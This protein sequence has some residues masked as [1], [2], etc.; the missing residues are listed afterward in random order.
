MNAVF[1]NLIL[2][3]PPGAGKGTQAKMMVEE[4]AIP[5]IS[6]GDILR[7]EVA[8]G[9]EL[10]KK[11]KSYMDAG[12]LVPDDLILK[13]V[14]GRLGQKDCA[15]GFILDG[16][17]RTIPQ[18]EGL[19]T[20]L[21]ELNKKLDGV[22]SIE[23]DDEEL[24]KRLT[25]RWISHSTG[26]IYNMLFDP[27]PQ[28]L[29]DSGDVYQ[30]DDDKEATVRNRLEVYKKKTEPLINYY[31]KSGLLLSILGTGEPADVLS[32]VK[33]TLHDKGL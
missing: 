21:K 9:S 27:P 8:Q 18:A 6:T 3:G 10:G 25:A 22:V 17:P 7:S 28:N 4:F 14:K 26:K 33:K 11:A 24:V 1:M 20:L 12:D 5:Q 16:F 23:V 32:R 19:G 29:I 2:L 15:Q 13:M 31:K 30:R